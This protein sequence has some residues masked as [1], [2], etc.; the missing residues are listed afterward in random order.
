MQLASPVFGCKIHQFARLVERNGERLLAQ[1]MFAGL[2]SRA[3]NG[4]VQRVGCQNMD[5]VDAGIFEQL[6]II[7]SGPVDANALTELARSFIAGAGHRHNFDSA[8]PAQIL[9]MHL[10]HETGSDESCL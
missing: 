2:E 9:R 7:S 6:L 1:N 8:Q 4:I 3:A 5:S 10:S